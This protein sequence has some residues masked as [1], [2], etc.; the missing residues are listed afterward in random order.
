MRER[1]RIVCDF[2]CKPHV[3]KCFLDYFQEKY[4]QRLIQNFIY[5]YKSTGYKILTI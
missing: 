5:E 3:I 2:S 4:S 1:E